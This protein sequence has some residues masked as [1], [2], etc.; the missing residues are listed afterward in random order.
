MSCIQAPMPMH[1]FSEFGF[2]NVQRSLHDEFALLQQ[3]HDAI[4]EFLEF[5]YLAP[6]CFPDA[7]HEVSCHHKSAFLALQGEVLQHAHRSLLE[8]LYAYY[9]VAF[10]LLWTTFELLRREHFGNASVVQN[11]GSEQ[12]SL[13]ALLQ[14]R[15]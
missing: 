7:K 11:S 3:S 1:I 2:E 6:L 8:A 12:S 13:M 14:D 10:I 9:N 4:H 5:L 15:R